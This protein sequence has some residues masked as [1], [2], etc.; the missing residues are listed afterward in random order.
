MS[1]LIPVHQ[2]ASA[3]WLVHSPTHKVATLESI[4]QGVPF[5]RTNPEQ[6]EA[7]AALTTVDVSQ[8]Q[9]ALP[10]SVLVV[11]N[12]GKAQEPVIVGVIQEPVVPEDEPTQEPVNVS[13][14]GHKLVLSAREEIELQCGQARIVLRKNGRISVRGVY[15]ET[16]A[17]GV[18]RIKGGAV[19]IN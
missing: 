9:E 8:L 18:N 15:V 14:D 7:Y 3:S 19:Q 5:V 16:R 11:F 6:Q 10:V 12:D 1:K 4:E 17:K 13:M 2:S